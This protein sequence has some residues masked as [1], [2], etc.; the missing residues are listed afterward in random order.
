MERGSQRIQSYAASNLPMLAR[1]GKWP[2]QWTFNGRSSIGEADTL[3]L[4]RGT[5]AAGWFLYGLVF[6]CG[7]VFLSKAI[8]GRSLSSIMLGCAWIGLMVPSLIAVVIP[9]PQFKTLARLTNGLLF[10]AMGAYLTLQGVSPV[11]L[12]LLPVGLYLGLYGLV[13]LWPAE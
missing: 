1:V 5:R 8:N 7:L 4:R 12:R 3:G 9:S 2:R 10:L 6:L 11:D 13:C